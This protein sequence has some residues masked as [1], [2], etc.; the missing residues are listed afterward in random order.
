MPNISDKP[1]KHP[2]HDR[3]FIRS[4]SDLRVAKEVLLQ[5]LPSD[6]LNAIEICKDKFHSVNLK[7]K[8][9]DMLYRL[10]LKQSVQPAYVAVLIEHQST[11]QKHMP[12]RVLSYEA[13]I[14]QQHWE[15]HDAVPLIYT[16]VYY[17]GSKPGLIPGISKT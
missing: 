6:L 1:N 4:M 17:N 11:P 10:P 2:V 7:G 15:R 13:A 5:H 12:V 14:M 8:I 3:F 9:T 16:L